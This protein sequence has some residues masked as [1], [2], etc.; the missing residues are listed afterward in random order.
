KQVT[1][2]D[3]T[4]TKG[5]E[6][7][8]RTAVVRQLG[9]AIGRLMRKVAVRFAEGKTEPVTI[10]PDDLAEML[11]PEQ[12]RPEQARRELPAGVATG[13]AWTEAGGE[14]LYVEANLLPHSRKL[15]I[16]GQLGKVMRESARAPQ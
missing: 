5:M 1:I 12:A 13:M 2:P 8:T 16:T 10:R 3:E 9:R 14:V 4:L 6:G 11:G 15:R 7:Y